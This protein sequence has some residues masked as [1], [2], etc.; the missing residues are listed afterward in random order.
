[1]SFNSN[2]SLY[3]KTAALA[4]A[5]AAIVTLTLELTFMGVM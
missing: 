1:M 3:L 2:R 5:I 4:A